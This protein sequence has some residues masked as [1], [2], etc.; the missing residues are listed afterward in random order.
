MNPYMSDPEDHYSRSQQHIF[1]VYR[2][3]QKSQLFLLISNSPL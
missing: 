1:P 3:D 2:K